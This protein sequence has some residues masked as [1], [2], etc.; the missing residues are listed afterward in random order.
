[1][2]TTIPVTIELTKEEHNAL[3]YVGSHSGG[4]LN[5]LKDAA[6]ESFPKPVLQLDCRLVEGAGGLTIDVD[7]DGDLRIDAG[8]DSDIVYLHEED[9]DALV[10]FLQSVRG[11]VRV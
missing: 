10:A 9:L 7:E 5:K 1:M 2:T 8:P 11:D 3:T 6:P 4:L